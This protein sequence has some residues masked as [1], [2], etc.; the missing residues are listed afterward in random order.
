MEATIG[1][2]CDTSKNYF[3]L[4]PFGSPSGLPGRKRRLRLLRHPLPNC[5]AIIL[6]KCP[7]IKTVPK[8]RLHILRKRH[9]V[10]QY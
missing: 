1:S 10:Q 9:V 8:H 3:L 7:D 6:A 5:P 4:V 2:Y